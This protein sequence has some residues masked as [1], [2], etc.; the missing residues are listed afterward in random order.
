MQTLHPVILLKNM[1]FNYLKS[2]LLLDIFSLIWKA[3]ATTI[4]AYTENELKTRHVLLGKDVFS[5]SGNKKCPP[6]L[7]HRTGSVHNDIQ[8][9]GIRLWRECLFMNGNNTG[10][11]SKAHLAPAVQNPDAQAGPAHQAGR[12]VRP[13]FQRQG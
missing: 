4:I 9:A 12:S 7:I 8:L 1:V 13:S 5:A 2:G 6:C 10:F 11:P 3:I